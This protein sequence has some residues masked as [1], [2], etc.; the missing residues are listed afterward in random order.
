MI[1]QLIF[2]LNCKPPVFLLSRHRHRD[3]TTPFVRSITLMVTLRGNKLGRFRFI[4]SADSNNNRTHK[5]NIYWLSNSNWYQIQLNMNGYSHDNKIQASREIRHTNKHV[6]PT[7]NCMTNYIIRVLR[8]LLGEF[9]AR[10]STCTC[11][12]VTLTRFG[13]TLSKSFGNAALYLSSVSVRTNMIL[14]GDYLN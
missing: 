4:H 9:Y 11:K 10:I 13:N 7:S 14:L 2:G 6:A 1:S 3:L 5:I 8:A 12:I